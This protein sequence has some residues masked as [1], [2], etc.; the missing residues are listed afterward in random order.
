MGVTV[1][2]VV[3]QQN[4]RIIVYILKKEKSEEN[5]AALPEPSHLS[6]GIISGLQWWNN[7]HLKKIIG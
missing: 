6:A 5:L 2:I 7:L 1:E 4:I 3:L